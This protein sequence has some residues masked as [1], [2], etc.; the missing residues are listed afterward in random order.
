MAEQTKTSKTFRGGIG[1]AVAVVLAWGL[2]EAIGV[3][4]PG[5]VTAAVGAIVGSIA[6][7]FRA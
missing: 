2:K 5:E 4:M 7:A 1:L 6:S 3:T